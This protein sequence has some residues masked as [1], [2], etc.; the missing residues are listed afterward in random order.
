MLGLKKILEIDQKWL[1]FKRE[2][3]SERLWYCLSS[4]KVWMPASARVRKWSLLG[5]ALINCLEIEPISYNSWKYCRGLSLVLG[6]NEHV[7]YIKVD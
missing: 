6:S 5:L 3:I 1:I 4:L 2:F 7:Y